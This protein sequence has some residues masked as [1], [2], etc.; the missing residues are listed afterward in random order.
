MPSREDLEGE[1]KPG[2]GEEVAGARAAKQQRKSASYGIEEDPQ[3]YRSSARGKT[4]TDMYRDERV[5]ERF[6]RAPTMVYWNPLLATDENGQV[7]IEFKV[8]NRETEMLLYVAAHAQG[9]LGALQTT[10]VSRAAE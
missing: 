8:P 9:R 5:L 1:S 6:D 10:I 4:A 2:I 7:T 3:S